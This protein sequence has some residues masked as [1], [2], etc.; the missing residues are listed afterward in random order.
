VP[1]LRRLHLEEGD[2]EDSEEAHA[3]RVAAD[4]GL[5]RLDQLATANQNAKTV[6]Y[7]RQVHGE[8]RRKWAA[9]DRTLHAKDDADHRDLPRSD[10]GA[11][12]NAES[13][14]SLRRAMIDA[15]R[16]AIIDLRDRDA[17]SD[18]VM[19]RV[20]RE[21]DLET[22]LLDSAEDDAPEPFDEE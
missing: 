14:R 4:A 21:L 2:E 18:D 3:R 1:L 8:R 6:D 17:I 9:R 10:G 12:R 15:E 22:M 7:L 11:E 16:A 20:Q 13:Y 5:R 19:R